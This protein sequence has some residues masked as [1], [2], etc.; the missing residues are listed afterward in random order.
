MAMIDPE[1][2]PDDSVPS[3][4][5]VDGD[6]K[7][8]AMAKPI[9]ISDVDENTK[10]E[11]APD[12]N[13]IKK[14]AVSSSPTEEQSSWF[15]KHKTFLIWSTIGIVIIAIVLAVVLPLITQ[16]PPTTVEDPPTTVDF[17]TG[18]SLVT[19]YHVET[20]VRSRLSR[21]TITLTVSNALDCSSIHAISFQLP[22]NTRIA[23]LKTFA[24]DGCETNGVV[25]EI[26]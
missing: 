23:S 26:A 16:V 24:S 12:D 22:M 4:S 18:V 3:S 9:M 5:S 14:N 19:S 7:S 11:Q 25:Q 8:V 20:R 2:S 15:T 10:S 21:T 17:S 6:N 13:P 1:Q